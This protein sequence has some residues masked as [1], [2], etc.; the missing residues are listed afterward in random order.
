MA[1]RRIADH[2]RA[3]RLST[4]SIVL[5][6]GEPLLLGRPAMRRTLAVLDARISPVAALDLRVH[7]NGVLLDEPWCELL[8]EYGVAV[9]ISL[10]GDKAANDRH[11]RFA[12]GRSSHPQ[13]SA[14]LA[15]LRRPE[16]RHLYA[17]ILCTID[18]A[19]DPEAVYQALV[20]E[21]P[22]RLDLLLPHA[23]WDRPPYRPVGQAA[24]YA[25]WLMRVYRSWDAGGRTVPIRFFD[26]LLSA[27]SGGPSFTEALGID[28]AG[29]LV[30]ETN[31]AWEQPDS[32]KTAFDGAA[33]TGMSVFGHSVD[34][35]SAHAA[36]VARRSGLDALCATCQRCPV[37][38]VCGGGLF[39][40]RFLSIGDGHRGDA[41]HDHAEFDNP[42]AYCDDLKSLITRVA[43]AER[44][45]ATPSPSA[46]TGPPDP[47]RSRTHRLTDDAFDL[48]AAGPGDVTAVREF[49]GLR[50]SQ[51]RRLLVEAALGRTAWRDGALRE[52]TEAGWS[53]LCELDRGFQPA[54]ADLFAQPYVSA[55]AWRCLR[56][57]PGADNELDRAH[58][59][60]LAAA[61]AVKA[62]VSVE[63]P[64]PVRHGMVHVPTV[65]AVTVAPGGST[66]V[67]SVRPGR[68]PT[69]SGGG[70]W[71]PVR[72]VSAP[73]FGRLAL[74]DLDPF[75]DCQEWPV[76]DRLGSSESRTWRRG[77][78]AAGRHL[79]D[80]VPDYAQ[81]LGFG[82]RAVV[83]LRAAPEGD[84]SATARHAF[85]AV[86]LAL[87]GPPVTR[88]GL[89]ELL[90]H[91]FQHAK[92]Y[93][94]ADMCRLVNPEYR[95][96]LRVPWRADP[97]PADGALHGTYA[98]LAL[99]HLGAAE[100]RRSRA[101]FLRHRS[102]VLD[103]TAALRAADG[104]LTS[105]G[106]RF[107]DGMAAAAEGAAW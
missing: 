71:R 85:G 38:R 58:L 61:A 37:V 33:A 39:A 65:G 74:E 97:R 64:L 12:D 36:I 10:D 16:Y 92:L 54:I 91:E 23:T 9:G 99:T 51:A 78:A 4:V 7:T 26:S 31:G 70:V 28:Q 104:A 73:P 87:P 60:G 40:H 43:A 66:R 24:P 75:R 50:L 83:P 81:V 69:I 41:A 22:P 5:H 67:L 102:W 35:A 57:P 42:S 6:G 2:A 3:H 95:R 25:D 19:N 47:A 32:M 55:W 62:G 101:A 94:L 14:A 8:R 18:L 77:L 79:T 103:A 100:G 29:V 59:A 45:R 1:A 15:V 53:Q 27:L 96:R 105:A 86:A 30:I 93:A 63:L 68:P 72:H 88:G 11:R 82:L 13:V 56:P 107:V 21:R 106:R 90:L 76:V 80:V 20:R 49:A 17:G 84:R 98:Y 89:S 46:R 34:E 44:P 48:L 52:A